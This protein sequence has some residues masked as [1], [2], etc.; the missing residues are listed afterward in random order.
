MQKIILVTVS[1]AQ[2]H[3]TLDARLIV[4]SLIFVFIDNILVDKFIKC[5][6]VTRWGQNVFS[7]NICVIEYE[8]CRIHLLVQQEVIYMGT[9]WRCGCLI[10][11]NSISGFKDSVLDVCDQ[12]VD[13][14]M[15]VVS[16]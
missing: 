8:Q 4:H 7:S 13:I 16:R 15:R 12:H 14:G 2:L 5:L 3:F 6:Q 1:D 9:I 11:Q 10:R